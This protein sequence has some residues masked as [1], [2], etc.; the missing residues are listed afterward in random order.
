MSEPT[1]SAIA[2]WDDILR[3]SEASYRAELARAAWEKS[4]D[5]KPLPQCMPCTSPSK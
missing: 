4:P 5:D 1:D 3:Q 2:M